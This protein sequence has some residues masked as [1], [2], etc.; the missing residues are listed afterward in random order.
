IIIP[1]CNGGRTL[2]LHLFNLK[3]ER[4]NYKK[5]TVLDLFIRCL[6]VNGLFYLLLSLILCLLLPSNIYFLILSILGFIQFV[7][8][9][10]SLFMIKCNYEQNGLQ[11]VFSQTQI[12]RTKM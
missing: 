2:G 3:I 7:L 6:I 12:V 1:F 4:N 5:I 9:I 10:I 11:D 8:V